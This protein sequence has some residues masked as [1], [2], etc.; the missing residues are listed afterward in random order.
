LIRNIVK[1]NPAAILESDERI[2]WRLEEIAG[3]SFVAVNKAWMEIQL[4]QCRTIQQQIM[5]SLKPMDFKHV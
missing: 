4:V 2:K 1:K 3:S 5:K